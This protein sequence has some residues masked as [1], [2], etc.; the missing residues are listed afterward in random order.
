M[1]YYNGDIGVVKSVTDDSL[2]VDIYG[3]EFVLAKELLDDVILAYATTIHKSQG[4]E[5]KTVFIVLP[6]SPQSML[7]RNLL[8][9]A[10]T[11]AKTKCVLLTT[12]Q[13]VNRAVKRC[14][15]YKRSSYLK[16]RIQ[17]MGQ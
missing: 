2:T 10:I 17:D 7:Q 6:N 12:P 11:R 5:Y 4:S 3:S 16:E 9:T 8:Y 1:G 15:T 14:D 13:A